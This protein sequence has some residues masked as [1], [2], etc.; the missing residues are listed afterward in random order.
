[1]PGSG[2][3]QVL[4]TD[5]EQFCI[6]WSCTSLAP[7]GHTGTKRLTLTETKQKPNRNPPILD[8]IWLLSRRREDFKV[9]MRGRIHETL[10]R[11]GLDPERL[12][13]SKNK[14]CVDDDDAND[15]VENGVAQQVENVN[16]ATA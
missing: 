2:R 7:L 12:V 6:L 3:Y 9:E 11:L 13:L 8:Q 14:G 5:Y 10:R 1:M 16:N 15:E 4:F